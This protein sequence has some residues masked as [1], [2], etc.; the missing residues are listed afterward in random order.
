MGMCLCGKRHRR[1]KIDIGYLGEEGTPSRNLKED[2]LKEVV[3]EKKE[4]FVG[5]EKG[6][7]GEERLGL[8]IGVF[9]RFEPMS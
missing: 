4:N 8:L 9:V 3:L 7:M 1:V 2:S 5:G 6:N